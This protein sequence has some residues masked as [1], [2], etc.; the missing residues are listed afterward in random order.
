MLLYVNKRICVA[1]KMVG[2]QMGRTGLVRGLP[3]G[4]LETSGTFGTLLRHCQTYGYV[5]WASA[6]HFRANMWE[7]WIAELTFQVTLG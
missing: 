1:A 3:S 6:C 2:R 7:M 5:A 4:A